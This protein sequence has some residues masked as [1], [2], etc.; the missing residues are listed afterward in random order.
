MRSPGGGC[1][2]WDGQTRLGPPKGP[3]QEAVAEAPQGLLD[4]DARR[5]WV[6]PSCGPDSEP[7][8]PGK[9]R[10]V[11][12]GPLRWLESQRCWQQEDALGASHRKALVHLKSC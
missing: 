6:L 8:P 7:G 4:L 11:A 12:T 2:R 9:P 1:T 5:T 10:I 3:L